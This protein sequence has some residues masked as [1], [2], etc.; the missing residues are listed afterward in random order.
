MGFLAPL[1]VKLHGDDYFDQIDDW[2]IR[3]SPRIRMIPGYKPC[4]NN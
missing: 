2:L 3:C 1:F 4:S